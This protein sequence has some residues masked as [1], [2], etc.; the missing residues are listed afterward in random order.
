MAGQ[1][2]MAPPL[3]AGL[4]TLSGSRLSVCM[5]VFNGVVRL[6]VFCFGED[7]YLRASPSF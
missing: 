1:R 7:V 2:T 4:M 5:A 3:S 6:G